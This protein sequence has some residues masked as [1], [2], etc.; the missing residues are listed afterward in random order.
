MKFSVR[1]TN[2]PLIEKL[3]G[4]EVLVGTWINM[5]RDPLIAR[6]VGGAG[7]D[8]VFIDMEHSSIT[9]NVVLDM[10]LIARDYG[11]TPIV[12]PNNP[13]NFPQN[14]RLLDIGAAGMI[15][16]HVNNKE[17]T[18]A[19]AASVR[20]FNDG[21]RGYC[22]TTANSCFEKNSEEHLKRSDSDVI[23]V[24]QFEDADAIAQA[25]EILSV[26]GIRM[27]VVG[28]GDLAH[29]MGLAGKQSDP[30]VIAEV[31][32]VIAACKRKNVAPGMLCGSTEEAKEWIA[33]GVRFIT[34][35]NEIA[36]L[37]DGYNK[38]LKAL[39]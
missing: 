27:A 4:N 22:G 9:E 2:N 38:A 26:P 1:Q 13:N 33:R 20:F 39:K 14:G 30:K 19:I 21:I 34:Y 12:R 29:S 37:Q 11:V 5:I 25:D 15:I 16:P 32:K 35:S 10:C 17:Q 24:A 6:I 23:L 28:R 8:Y 31:E 3:K 7:L 18:E 36:L